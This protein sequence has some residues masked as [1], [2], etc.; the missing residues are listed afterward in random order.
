MEFGI[1]SFAMSIVPLP[2]GAGAG[3]LVEVPVKEFILP[4]GEAAR[5]GERI[6]HMAGEACILERLA[7]ALAEQGWTET[8]ITLLIQELLPSTE[9]DDDE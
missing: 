6:S 7:G 2:D 4:I 9:D 3:V 1:S 5:F 8:A